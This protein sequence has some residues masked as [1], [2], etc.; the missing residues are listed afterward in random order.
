MKVD[1]EVIYY[2]SQQRKHYKDLVELWKQKAKVGKVQEVKKGSVMI[3][4]EEVPKMFVRTARQWTWYKFWRR[5]GFNRNL[6][7][8]LF[9][10]LFFVIF[11]R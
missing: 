6:Y 4:G 8:Y 2:D 11:I 7:Y 3:N 5:K 10:I 1:T 9:V